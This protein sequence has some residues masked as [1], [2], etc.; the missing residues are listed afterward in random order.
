MFDEEKKIS[1]LDVYSVV[2]TIDFIKVYNDMIKYYNDK[3][4]CDY[5]FL[6]V[7][8]SIT[9]IKNINEGNVSVNT[10]KVNKKGYIYRV[11]L[12]EKLS[13]N[14]LTIGVGKFNFIGGG[15][16]AIKNKNES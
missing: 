9:M 16:V 1:E 2:E 5:K 6:K 11:C 7:V 15:K 10:R 14:L 4:Q 12:D 3:Y 13:L 8:S